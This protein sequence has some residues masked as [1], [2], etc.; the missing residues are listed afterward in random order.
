MNPAGRLYTILATYRGNASTN[1]AIWTTWKATF[2]TESDHDTMVLL[3]KS[4]ALLGDVQVAVERAGHPLMTDLFGQH[5]DRWGSTLW[6]STNLHARPSPGESHVDMD[7]LLALGSLAVFLETRVV[8]GT[9]PAAEVMDPLKDEVRS[10][11]DAVS[12]DA[13]LPAEL[14]LIILERLHDI[15]WAM[16]H[17]WLG[18]PDA[19]QAAIERLIAQ[20]VF[21]TSEAERQQAQPFL[22]RLFDVAGNIWKAF[23]TGDQ[24]IKAMENYTKTIG[25][26]TS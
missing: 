11:I 15:T 2:N 13:S 26:L 10:L 20:I 17:V 25:E 22:K 12:T 7:S 21:R 1:A 3:G 14:R 18:G 6:T 8:D 4:A 5:R 23:L 16:D 9:V 19:I 24:A